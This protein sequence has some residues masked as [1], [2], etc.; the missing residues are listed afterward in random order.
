MAEIKK[1]IAPAKVAEPVKEEV[2]TVAAKKE[3]APKKAAAKKETVKKAAA[4]KKAAT[5]AVA[6]KKEAAPKKEAAKKETVKKAA[7]PK[8]AATK[9]VAAKET[10]AIQFAGKDISTEAIIKLAKENYKGNKNKEAIKTLN[11]YVNVDDNR[12]YYVVNDK[13]E[14]SYPI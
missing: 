3:A 5:K 11:V 14:G 10:V 4:P 8:K 1:A 13:I 7:A 2:K 6:A 9:A 12:V